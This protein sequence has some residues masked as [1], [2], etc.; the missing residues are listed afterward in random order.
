MKIALTG[1]VMLSRRVNG[2]MVCNPA[3]KPE[4]FWGD[5][6]PTMLACELRMANLECVISRKREPWRPDYKVFH[7]RTH[8]KAI[9]FLKRQRLI[10]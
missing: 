8:P 5:I 2:Y 6:L 10:V 1:Y 9:E 4:F 3:V 7:F